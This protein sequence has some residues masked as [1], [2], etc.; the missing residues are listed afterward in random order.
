MVNRNL[1]RFSKGK[2]Q[3]LHLGKKDSIYQ[4]KL[5][6]QQAESSSADQDLKA[7]MDSK[8]TINQQCTLITERANN[9]LGY[10]RQNTDSR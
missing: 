10:I 8:M 3:V 9:L 7:P 4:H 5:E 6:G 1:K 2:C